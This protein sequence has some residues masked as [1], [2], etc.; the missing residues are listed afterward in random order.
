MAT[1]F[2]LECEMCD[3]LGPWLRWGHSGVKVLPEAQ[4]EWDL[5]LNEHEWHGLKLRHE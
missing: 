2:Q 1:E 5:F 3:A 4:E